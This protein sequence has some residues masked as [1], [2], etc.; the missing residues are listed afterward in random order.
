MSSQRRRG[1]TLI[2]LLVVI[3]IIGVLIG[4]LLP[5]V[6]AAR[7]AARRVQ[8]ASNLRQAG[9][10]L[11]G[12]LNAKNF[13]PNAATFRE[14]DGQN[15]TTAL[16]A[17][18]ASS[19]SIIYTSSLGATATGANAS[20]PDYGPLHS[21]VVD[22][23]PYLDA[24]ELANAWNNDEAWYSNTATNG[25]PGNIYAAEKS[26]GI[27]TCPEDLTVQPGNGNLSFVVNLGFSRWV[28]DTTIGWT[29][30][31]A[32]L[33]SSTTT[34]PNWSGQTTP[35]TANVPWGSRTGV[36]F[37]GTT[38][39]KFSWDS[40]TTSTTMVDGASQTILGSENVLAG[41]SQSNPAIGNN[42]SNWATAHPNVIGFIASDKIAPSGS[43]T[44]LANNGTA[45]DAS[46]WAA[47]NPP[48]TGVQE[49]INAGAKNVNAL[50][51]TSPYI[52]S[53]H[54]GGANVLFC[55]GAVRFLSETIDGTVYSKLITPAGSKLPVYKQLPL[56]SDEF[57]AN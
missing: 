28:G 45:A 24:T 34:G 4:L 33:G 17:G 39:G 13:Y 26:I 52:S 31:A 40:K 12:F 42:A 51:G 23:L 22:V 19:A 3:S 54:T 35:G 20:G 29:V 2:E 1:F 50:E 16:P 21:W 43:C 25:N 7:K 5:A 41:Y 10:G 57:G 11:N 9:L 37:L 55:D 30:T 8:C 15:G 27:L 6:Q 14:P 56:G 53:N 47:A 18:S 38:T 32:G 49:Y 46:G 36:M 44:N 48:R